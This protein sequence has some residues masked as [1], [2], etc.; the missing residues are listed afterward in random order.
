M[1]IRETRRAAPHTFPSFDFS[2][3]SVRGSATIT[4][5]KG[6]LVHSEE[7]G[8]VQCYSPLSWLIINCYISQNIVSAR[9]STTIVYVDHTLALS[10]FGTIP[11]AGHRHHSK[12]I[13]LPPHA[14]RDRPRALMQ[15]QYFYGANN[16]PILNPKMLQQQ[17][18]M[19]MLMAA[20]QASSQLE[21]QAVSA[22]TMASTRNYGYLPQQQQF[23][24]QQSPYG[25][26]S[27]YLQTTNPPQPHQQPYTNQQ[28]G[29]PT[30]QI[31]IPNQQQR[32]QC[33]AP[34][35]STPHEQLSPRANHISSKSHRGDNIYT[36]SKHRSNG[37]KD[38]A[39]P[40]QS[41][42]RR[43]APPSRSPSYSSSPS[44][45][46]LSG[47]TEAPRATDEAGRHHRHPRHGDCARRPPHQDDTGD[48]R[49][50]RRTGEQRQFRQEEK[51]SE[52]TGLE[53]AGR[54]TVDDT[55]HRRSTR[56]KK[57]HRHRDRQK[58]EH[59]HR[60]GGGDR[61]GDRGDSEKRENNGGRRRRRRCPPGEDQRPPASSPETTPT[62]LLAPPCITSAPAPTA[63]FATVLS[64][65]PVVDNAQTR[66]LPRP[67]SKEDR[68]NLRRHRRRGAHTKRDG[69]PAGKQGPDTLKEDARSG[70]SHHG[71]DGFSI[72]RR[73]Q[74]ID[75]RSDSSTSA[76]S[77]I[78]ERGGRRKGRVS[79]EHGRQRGR[80]R[81]RKTKKDRRSDSHSHSRTSRSRSGRAHS[82]SFSANPSHP[83]P[84][85][86]E[87]RPSSGGFFGL[88][89]AKHKEGKVVES[90]AS[91]Q[92]HELANPILTTA[93]PKPLCS[94]VPTAELLLQEMPKVH[95]SSHATDQPLPHAHVGKDGSPK[96]KKK[97]TPLCWPLQKHAQG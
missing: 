85:G 25:T 17:Q 19:A 60:H 87:T 5:K 40:Q 42:Q 34:I 47:N 96:Q 33:A 15:P 62:T 76:R 69:A 6:I 20:P 54:H 81:D 12:A 64:P 21:H 79:E 43:R 26:H 41:P 74:E 97:Q 44:P 57:D 3:L 31:I 51:R 46:S 67:Q 39:T 63:I 4:G 86:T 95:G 78:S 80:G 8:G 16:R 75:S 37:A 52:S 93:Q 18:Q 55:A 14:H 24:G 82:L 68:A 7:K 32:Q 56:K 70:D 71:G 2:P 61:D 92:D 28:W 65:P 11:L 49:K 53:A 9:S 72:N 27:M 29:Q 91:Q 90:T 10:L 35:D 48:D 94:G 84:P 89:R 50:G 77:R 22:A 66:T 59:R 58:Y 45:L 83:I 1:L 88:F 73:K 30:S 36:S 38:T 13:Q 23:Q